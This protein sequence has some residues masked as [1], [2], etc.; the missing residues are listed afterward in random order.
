MLVY[1]CD[2]GYLDV[3]KEL[4]KLGVDVNLKMLLIFVCKEGYIDIVEELIKEGV[5]VN[6]EDG[7][8]IFLIYV[9]DGGYL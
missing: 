4:I 1:V 7:N 6:L 9:Y 5:D 3:V 2:K 8:K